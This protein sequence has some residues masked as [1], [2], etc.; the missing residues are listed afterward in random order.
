M[1]QHIPVHKM[2]ERNGIGLEMLYFQS[3][4]KNRA[5]LLGAHR[6]DHY[7]FIFQEEGDTQVMLDF[8]TID[9]KG[10]ALLYIIPGQVHHILNTERSSGWFLAVETLLVAD[11]YRQI[12]EHVI[13]EQEALMLDPVAEAKFKQ[14]IQLVHERFLDM[15]QPLSKQIVHSLLSSYIGMTTEAYLLSK[16]KSEA[17]NTRPVQLTRQFRTLLLQDFKT[18]KGPAEYA[19]KLNISLT[20]LNEVVK[21]NTGFPVSYWIHHEIILEAKR[22]LYHTDLSLKE[23][24][25]SLGFADHTYFSRLFTK[26]AGGSAG[27]FR[28]SYR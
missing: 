24:A 4:D 25:F 13:L 6:D 5:T 20:Y 15:N 22:L 12:L 10:S 23:I 28:K 26:V 2:A 18:V 8:K 16:P 9:V 1:K 3:I 14:C 11:E 21:S 27:K 17:L 7:I 19:A